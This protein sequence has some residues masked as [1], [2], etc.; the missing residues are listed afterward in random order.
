VFVIIDTDDI[1]DLRVV[2]WDVLMD[3]E[4]QTALFDTYVSAEEYAERH[5]GEYQIV[6]IDE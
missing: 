3:T 4:I 5:C 2:K 6:E 1:T